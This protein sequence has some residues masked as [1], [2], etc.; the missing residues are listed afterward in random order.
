[1]EMLDSCLCAN[2]REFQNF[3]NVV[4]TGSIGI[5]SLNDTNLEFLR[6]AG[7]A[8]KISNEGSGKSSNTVAV[9]QAENVV[10]VDEVVYQP[11]RVAIQGCTAV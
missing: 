11:I 4:C 3:L 10:L 2:G 6:N 9:E 5:S 1:M 7:V 8:G